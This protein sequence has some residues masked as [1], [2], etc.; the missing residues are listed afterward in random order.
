MGEE[1]GEEDDSLTFTTHVTHPHTTH[2]HTH[3]HTHMHTHIHL[4][5]YG[6]LASEQDSSGGRSKR[7]D[8]LSEVQKRELRQMRKRQRVEHRKRKVLK[9]DDEGVSEEGRCGLR[10]EGRLGVVKGGGCECWEEGLE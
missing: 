1:Q 3:M 7:M 4:Q 10:G 9:L 2:A 8:R 5:E 6:L